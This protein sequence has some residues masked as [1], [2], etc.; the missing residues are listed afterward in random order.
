MSNP[1]YRMQQSSRPRP[2]PLDFASSRA[3]SPSYRSS[4][5]LS[6]RA[7]DDSQ[8]LLYDLPS[9]PTSP[10]SMGMGM[11]VGSRTSIGMGMGSPP[12]S[13]RSPTG[14][15]PHSRTGTGGRPTPPPSARMRSTTPLGFAPSELES[16][17]E[18]C[19]AWYFHQDPKAGTLMTQTLATLPPSQKASFSRV[20]ASIRAAYHR[21][22]HLRRHAEFRAHLAATTP[23]ASLS[24]HARADPR[25]AGAQ[26]ERYER[27]E[28]FVCNW[29]TAGLPGTKPFFEA[30]WALM[31]LQVIPEDLG[32]AG[33]SRIEWEFDDAVF[34]EAAGKDFMLEAIDVLKGVLAFEDLSSSKI[35]SPYTSHT[36]DTSLASIHARSYSQPLASASM[37]TNPNFTS[38]TTET[39]SIAKRARAP[40][41][42]FLDA[43]PALARGAPQAD[44]RGSPFGVSGPSR[45]GY[46]GEDSEEGMG[47]VRRRDPFGL[48]D[49]LEEEE[50][51]EYMRTWIAP[52]LANPE[53][54]ELLKLFPT[55]ITRRPLPR[56]PQAGTVA[57]GNGIGTQRRRRASSDLERGYGEGGG[58]EERIRVGTGAM[59]V[60]ERSRADGWEG[61][62]WVRFVLWWKRVFSC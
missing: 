55:F 29:C 5:I 56:F 12:T 50:P 8:T 16:F 53:L 40:S 23:G 58:G 7:V 43:S 39:T 42:P 13:P 61:S 28:R 24:P 49:G 59:W 31:R 18:Y 46:V 41:D 17:A 60:G 48:E 35:P 20:Q 15:R 6:P 9:P 36:K 2:S 14:F 22:V 54:L 10:R 51:E 30:L 38:A 32:G 33:N 21:S 25:G 27:F 37:S 1:S 19:R 4:T 52:D 57:S 44:E 34:K 47:G 26:K 11:G 62:W 3:P 45:S